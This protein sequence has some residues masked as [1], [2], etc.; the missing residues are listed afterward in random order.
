M[1]L[2][3]ADH[4]RQRSIDMVELVADLRDI[5]TDAHDIYLFGS[6]RFKTGSV[7]SD[8]DLLV[9]MNGRITRAQAEE[10]WELEPYAD[11]FYGGSGSAQSIVNE[12]VIAASDTAA[13]IA[14]L[15]AQPL[16]VGGA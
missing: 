14:M 5:L 13:L 1:P 10:I 8:I 6:R 7:R 11:V 9:I 16:I 15:D 2:R 4:P 3:R 12:S